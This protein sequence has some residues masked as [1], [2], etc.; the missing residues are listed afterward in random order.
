[1]IIYNLLYQI[2]RS[3]AEDRRERE[4]ELV[5]AEMIPTG[6]TQLTFWEKFLE[7]QYKMIA[8]APDAPLGH[9]FASEPAEWPLL[10]RSIAYWLS[11]NSNVSVSAHIH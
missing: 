9:M 10:A 5:T 8:H 2:L 3:P 6:A 4:R 11:P 7:L 1:M